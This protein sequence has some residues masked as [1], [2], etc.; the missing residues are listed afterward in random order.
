MQP[1]S[2]KSETAVIFLNRIRRPYPSGR[3]IEAVSRKQKVA[4]AGRERSRNT[5]DQIAGL[6]KEAEGA[7]SPKVLSSIVERIY[8]GSLLNASDAE[9][10]RAASDLLR[11]TNQ[12][13]SDLE[14]TQAGTGKWRRVTAVALAALVGLMIAGAVFFALRLRERAV[15]VQ[16]SV[17]PDRSNIEIAGQDCQSPECTFHLKPGQYVVH[18]QKAGYK[19]R[20]VFVSVKSGDSTPL[21]LNAALEPLAAASAATADPLARLEIRGALPKTRIRLDGNDIGAASNDGIFLL[22]VSPGTHTLD[23]SLDGFNKRTIKR[24]FARGETVSLVDAA[25]QLE[26]QRSVQR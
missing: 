26:P 19:P 16:I 4:E 7:R 18:I 14:I 23:L 17:T 11:R 8:E 15:P 5:L 21:K 24:D 3:W 9:V 20:S 13:L 25:V 12:R 22:Q 6:S 1:T 10:R 2:C